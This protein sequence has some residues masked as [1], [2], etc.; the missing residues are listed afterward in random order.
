MH[1]KLV[2]EGRSAVHHTFLEV[3][4]QKA[5]SFTSQVLFRGAEIRNT[6]HVRMSGEDAECT[7]NGLYVGSERQVIE[8]HT[9]I[10][11]QK[12][13][14]TSREVYK[15]ILDDQSR[16]VFDGLIIVQRREGAKRRI[17]FRPIRIYSCSHRKRTPRPIRS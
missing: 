6:I 4:V 11:H 14:G 1:Y 17:R 8:S 7:L 9:L 13:R 10:E 15:G 16:G 2:H 3:D 5:A 12:P